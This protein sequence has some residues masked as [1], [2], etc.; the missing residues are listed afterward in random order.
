MKR[1]KLWWAKLRR[2]WVDPFPAEFQEREREGQRRIPIEIV[3][4]LAADGKVYQRRRRQDGDR[5]VDDPT[6]VAMVHTE[7]RYL[8]QQ[9]R[10]S[11]RLRKLVGK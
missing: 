9:A 5:R 6:I 1:L 8:V 2:W 4:I 10:R 7:Y 3:F 11:A